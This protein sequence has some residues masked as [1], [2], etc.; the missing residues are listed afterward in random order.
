MAQNVP[1]TGVV[2]GAENNPE[3][4][5]LGLVLA[6]FKL[7]ERGG[8][9]PDNKSGDQAEQRVKVISPPVHKICGALDFLRGT[10]FMMASH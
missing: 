6:L 8:D 4:G 9:F 7:D 3:D 5:D 2:G 10:T 1:L